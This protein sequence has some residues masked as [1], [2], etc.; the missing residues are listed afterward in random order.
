MLL[1][2][3]LGI[4]YSMKDNR[5]LLPNAKFSKIF[6]HSGKES[7]FFFIFAKHTMSYKQEVEI[8]PQIKS[9]VFQTEKK[10]FLV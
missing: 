2:S 7:D 8:E 5:I 1:T 4:Y 3:Q 9:G 6:S 10:M